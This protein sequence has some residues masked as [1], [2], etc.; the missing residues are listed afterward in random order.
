MSG[1]DKV[2]IGVFRKRH[3]VV[4]FKA[5]IRNFRGGSEDMHKE[6]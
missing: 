1:S 6:T 4:C 3:L 5:L 2:V